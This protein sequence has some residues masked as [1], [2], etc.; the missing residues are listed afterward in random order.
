MTI[1]KGVLVAL[2][3]LVYE[4]ERPYLE[5]IGDKYRIVDDCEEISKVE[6]D[7]LETAETVLKML[8]FGELKAYD[9]GHYDG[10]ISAR[11]WSA[12]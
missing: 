10:V 6:F 3:H 1:L 4:R 9:M 2:V 7:D 12:R 11:F 8:R 5:P